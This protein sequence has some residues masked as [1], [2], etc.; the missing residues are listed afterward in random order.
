MVPV[1]SVIRTFFREPVQPMTG[2]FSL[3]TFEISFQREWVFQ[4][5]SLI[6][7][8]LCHHDT[9]NQLGG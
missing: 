5:V 4:L 8:N 6:S 3:T 1:M 7:Y 9:R 2:S